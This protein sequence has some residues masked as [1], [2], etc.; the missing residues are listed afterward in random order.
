MPR[1]EAGWRRT[2]WSLRALIAGEVGGEV[3]VFPSARAVID[4]EAV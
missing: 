4:D 1:M 2:V 3:A